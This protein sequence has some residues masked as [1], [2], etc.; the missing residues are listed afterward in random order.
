MKKTILF[1]SAI[2]LFALSA[3][4][5]LWRVNN[6]TGIS[7]NFTTLSA[8]ISA[9][10][11]G[12]TIYVEPTGSS[13]GGG[14]IDKKLTIIGN[15]YFNTTSQS[16]SSM[17]PNLQANMVN[18]VVGSI[19]LAV[20]SQN[21]TIMGLYVSGDI[22]TYESNINIKRCYITSAIRLSNY[23]SGNYVNISNIDIRQNIIIGGL[24]SNQFNTNS[25][26]VSMTNV[27]VQNN[28]LSAYY[29][30]QIQLPSGISGFMMNNTFYTPYYYL[31]VYNFQINNNISIGGSFNVNNNVYF[32]NIATNSYW[33][34]ANNNQANISTTALFQNYGSNNADTCY[35]LNPSGP[36]VGTGFNSVDVGPYGG[37]D[38]YRKSGVPP[39]PAIYMFSAPATT[40]TS[41]LPVTISTRSND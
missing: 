20:G 19:T 16:M 6:I 8:A 10:S 37:P 11:T 15:G 34:T 13:V 23:Q 38:P 1:L 27:N 40:T 26:A 28:I 3:N 32:N 36:G 33:G 14:T 7:T 21:S 12:D 18:S 30:T 29:Y 25:G 41:T 22:Y 35:V 31:D 2:V 39:V 4:A 5:A 9:A 17:N 24:V